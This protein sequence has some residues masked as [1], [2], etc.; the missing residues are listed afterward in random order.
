MIPTIVPFPQKDQKLYLDGFLFGRWKK[1]YG[2]S[3]VFQ[4]Y[5]EVEATTKQYPVK[6]PPLKTQRYGFGELFASI[7]Y[8][9]LGYEVFCHHWC[10]DDD[11]AGYAKAVKIL[12]PKAASFICLGYGR[13][14]A[15]GL[16]VIYRRGRF[17]FVE[18][19]LPKD[20]LSKSQIRFF[21]RIESY[22]NKNI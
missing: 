14:H 1:K 20:R 15:P 7:R 13:T 18:A 3:A 10:K 4:S 9:D 5:L 16:L 17:F 2:H 12:G 6:A 19:K 22:L 21:R 8:L 11:C